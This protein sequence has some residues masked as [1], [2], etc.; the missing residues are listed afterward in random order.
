MAEFRQAGGKIDITATKAIA[1][2]EV[3]VIGNIIVVAS[4]SASIG[5]KTSAYTEGVYEIKKGD[6]E[7]TQGAKVYLT[8]DGAITATAEGNTYAGIAWRNATA[9]D[10]VADVKINA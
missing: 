10:V 5:E 6:G 2:H 9:N 3:V 8:A 1:Y 7:I 4:H